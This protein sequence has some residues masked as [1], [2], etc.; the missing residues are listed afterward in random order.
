[1]FMVLRLSTILLSFVPISTITYS[2]VF[3]EKSYHPEFEKRACLVRRNHLFFTHSF[4][5][6][7]IADF[8]GF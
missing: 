2:G 3:Q 4:A 5:I 6:M 1:P 7:K 8:I